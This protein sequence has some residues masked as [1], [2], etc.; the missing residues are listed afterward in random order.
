MLTRRLIHCVDDD[1]D[2]SFMLT[3]LLIQEGYEARSVD[4]TQS[5][6]NP[7]FYTVASSKGGIPIVAGVFQRT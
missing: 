6:K 3:Y 1:R 7:D 5:V 2:T 4:F